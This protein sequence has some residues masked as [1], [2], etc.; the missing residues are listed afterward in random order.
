[1]NKG[2]FWR[3]IVILFTFI[4]SLAALVTFREGSL[5]WYLWLTAL[6]VSSDTLASDLRRWLKR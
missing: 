6:F 4:G 3:V 2:F 1:M 5:V